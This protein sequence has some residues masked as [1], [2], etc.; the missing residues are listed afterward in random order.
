MARRRQ[1]AAADG[2]RDLR[3]PPAR[4]VERPSPPGAPLFVFL[5]EPGLGDLALAELKH[6]K[7]VA[8]QARPLRLNLRSHDML[9]LP[10]GLVDIGRARSRLCTNVLAAPVFGRGAITPGQLDH[11]AAVFRGPAGISGW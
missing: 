9:V 11:L 2:R 10:G 8:R 6:L 7:L 4:P 3:A 5:A 1:A